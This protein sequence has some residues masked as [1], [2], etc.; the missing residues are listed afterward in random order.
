MGKKSYWWIW[1]VDGG[2]PFRDGPF[3]NDTEAHRAG[4]GRGLADFETVEL[5]TKVSS[6]AGRMIKHIKFERN[7]PMQEVFRRMK[8]N[9][10][11]EQPSA[12]KES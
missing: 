11:R 7:M 2:Y 4:I 6:V 1:G 10:Q 8:L 3:N 12:D 5:P 9:P